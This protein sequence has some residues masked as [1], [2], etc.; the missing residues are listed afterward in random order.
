[1]DDRKS[2]SEQTHIQIVEATHNNLRNITV[3]IPKNKLTVI[4]GVSGSGKSSLAFD[5]IYGEAQRKYLEQMSSSEKRNMPVPPRA[6][7]LKTKGLVP[8]LALKQSKIVNNPRSTVGS[9]TDLFNLVRILYMTQ[10][11]TSCFDCNHILKQVSVP[12]LTEHLSSLPEGTQVEIRV[13]IEKSTNETYKEFID[14]YRARGYK[15]IYINDISFSLDDTTDKDFPDLCKI[16]ILADLFTITKDSYRQIS[17]SINSIESNCCDSILIRVEILNE[18]NIVLGKGRN[19]YKELGCSEHCY[20]MLPLNASR[21][22]LKNTKALC[23][24]CNGIG[25]T[26]VGDSRLLVTNP[27][28]SIYSGALHRRVYNMTKNSYNGVVLYSLSLHYNFS[29]TEPYETLPDKIKDIIMYGTNGELIEMINPPDIR[30]AS[31]IV[32]R[33]MPFYGF[34][35]SLERHYHSTVKRRAEG[36]NVNVE[37]ERE[38]LIETI[39]TDC[40]GVRF[41]QSLANVMFLDKTF[42][43]MMQMQL[44]DIKEYASNVIA[45]KSTHESAIVILQEIYSKTKMMCDVGLYYLNLGRKADTLSGGETQRVKMANQVSSDLMGLLYVLDEPSVGLHPKDIDNVVRIVKALRDAGNTVIVVEHDLEIIAQADYVIE[46][47]PRAGLMGGGLVYAGAIKGLFECEESTTR[48]YLNKSN[49]PYFGKPRIGST[50]TLKVI[51]ACEN[52]LKNVDVEIPLGRFV[53]VTGVSGSGKST[54]VNNI[55]VNQL[56]VSKLRK[57][58]LVG[59]HDRIEGSEYID[60]VFH[61]DQNQ[62]YTSSRSSPATYINIFDRIRKLYAELPE[63]KEKGYTAE[64]FSLTRTNGLRCENCE[65]YGIIITKLQFMPDV[66]TVC[67]ICKGDCYVEECMSFLYKDK[68]IPQVMGMSIEEAVNFFDDKYIKHKLNFMIDVGLGYLTLGQRLDT[69]SGGEAQRLK[70]SYELSKLKRG[71]HNLYALDEPT[72]GLNA[73]DIAKLIVCFNKMVDAG[74][75]VIIIEHNLDII[76]C[77]DYV[78]D[79]GPLGGID[80]GEVIFKGT[81]AEL[82]Q[83]GDYSFTGKALFP[84]FK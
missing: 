22:S 34:I 16:E 27:K 13:P 47:G 79:M 78:I 82:A 70:L 58:I 68:S 25:Y 53:C 30:A 62:L 71:T 48:K 61:I 1:M 38:C 26:Y 84:F 5:V 33:T 69:L 49:E 41:K 56:L 4:T 18:E 64:E 65:G 21:Y 57:P 51:N 10:G 52:N 20:I 32:G 83:H 15:K 72:T 2:V 35:E 9:I 40:C 73:F 67:P 46:L 77:A 55:I 36:A 60:S 75:T 6:K 12:K 81:P 59:K 29:L 76:K 8:A 42:R 23:K 66:I 39:C 19:F 31:Y 54:L 3:D 74:H 28:R 50:Q 17:K 11:V 63:V 80:G 44:I 14:D 43:D 24:S 45:E 7:V 37:S